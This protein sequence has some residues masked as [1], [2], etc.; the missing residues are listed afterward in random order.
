MQMG[1][2]EYSSFPK[3][4]EEQNKA[5]SRFPKV[6][7]HKIRRCSLSLKYGSAKQKYFDRSSFINDKYYNNF[8]SV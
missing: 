6:W 8:S 1:N 5:F 2:K 3:N 4:M 7:K